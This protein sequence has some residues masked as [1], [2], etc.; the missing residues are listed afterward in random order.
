[1]SGPCMVL[2]EHVFG[3]QL[4]IRHQDLYMSSNILLL[5]Q[6]FMLV[7]ARIT[8]QGAPIV[9]CV[10]VPLV[11]VRQAQCGHAVSD[12]RWV[13]DSGPSGHVLEQQLLSI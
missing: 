10:E 7:T 12:H 9:L 3:K 5:Q 2:L 6:R 4:D 11:W 13:K 8:M 1:M